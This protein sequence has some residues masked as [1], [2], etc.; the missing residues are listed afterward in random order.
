MKMGLK[1][2]LAVFLSILM[3]LPAIMA[4]LPMS[5]A[6]TFAAVADAYVS[7]SYVSGYGQKTIQVEAGEEFYVGDYAYISDYSSGAYGVASN[8]DVSYTSS[9]KAVAKVDKNGYFIAR[10][11]GTTKV[12]VKYKGVKA[13]CKFKV[14][15]AGTFDNTEAITA[16]NA[17][18]DILASDIPSKVTTKNGYSLIQ[19]TVAFEE[20]REEYLSE[21]N[22]NGFLME[23][24]EGAAY[25]SPSTKL[26]VPQAGRYKYLTHLLYAYEE[27][28]SPISTRSSKVLKIASVSANRKAITINLK[29]K[30][31]AA[32]LL[33]AQIAQSGY[34]NSPLTLTADAGVVRVNITDVKT[35]E[36]Y[37]G[38]LTLKKGAKKVK[39]VPM[40][41]KSVNGILTYYSAKLKKGHTYRLDSTVGWTKGKT[42]KVK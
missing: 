18:A 3:I 33:A 28:N 2:R 6:D 16:V 13:V 15:K 10:K 29:K 19:K 23:K 26:V 8:F 7:W 39:L 27:K 34:Y 24:L 32:Q 5:A 4:V 1:R 42:V 12:T 37:T 36:V 41:S 38:F 17:A 30:V 20:A 11:P 25:S 9:K 40:K 21:I 22:S 31:K 35:N 14:V